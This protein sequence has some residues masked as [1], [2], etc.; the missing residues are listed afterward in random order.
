M[1]TLVIG[2]VRSGKSRWAEE[3]IRA[4]TLP[5][6]PV[7]LA[8]SLP[9][10]PEMKA[11]IA[12]HRRQ[13]DERFETHE[14]DYH[15]E[16][17]AGVLT[18]YAEQGRVVLFECMSTWVGW[19]LTCDPDLERCLGTFQRQKD[20]LLECLAHPGHRLYLI[21]NEVGCG[22]VG[23]NPLAR[24]FADQLGWLNQALAQQC[25][26]VTALVAGLPLR[27]KSN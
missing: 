23:A 8:S 12:R 26:Q 21:S 4:Q 7:Y 14:L 20:A 9:S 27:L 1:K 5:A 17:L 3:Q 18:G 25:D 10:D 16:T 6:Q 19:W 22:L 24:A 13:R 11:R 15:R 2:G